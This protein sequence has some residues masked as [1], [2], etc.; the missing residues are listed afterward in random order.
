MTPRPWDLPSPFLSCVLRVP[1]LSVERDRQNNESRR[2]PDGLPIGEG[3]VERNID[4]R[5]DKDNGCDGFGAPAATQR[6]ACQERQHYAGYHGGGER[7][8]GKITVARVE[9]QTERG[10]NRQ[11]GGRD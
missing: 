4:G 9:D 10:L 6:D 2:E 1:S 3:F 7:R 8:V 5:A 11:H